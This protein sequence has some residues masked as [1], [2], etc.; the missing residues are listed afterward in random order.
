MNG[1]GFAGDSQRGVRCDK[2]KRKKKRR[3]P[4]FNQRRLV[5]TAE[6]AK[7]LLRRRSPASSDARVARQTFAHDVPFFFSRDVYNYKIRACAQSCVLFFQALLQVNQFKE[8][9]LHC[10]AFTEEAQL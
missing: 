4:P 7:Q 3:A 5:Q 6:P 8:E 1:A 9:K 2:K 10:V